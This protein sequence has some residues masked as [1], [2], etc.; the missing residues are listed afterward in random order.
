M[1]NSPIRVRE[2]ENRP[3][4]YVD[5]EYTYEELLETFPDGGTDVVNPLVRRC[6]EYEG[7][8]AKLETEVARMRATVDQFFKTRD[9]VTIVPGMTVFGRW[10]GAATVKHIRDD[11]L[12]LIAQPS[13]WIYRKPDELFSNAEA[14]REAKP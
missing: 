8:I 7:R 11:G 3:A 14:A 4:T 1:M 10:K 13:A 2:I 6:Q 9:G 12:V 5:R